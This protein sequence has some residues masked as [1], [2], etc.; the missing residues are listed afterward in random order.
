M[1]LFDP[2]LPAAADPQPELRP[3]RRRRKRRVVPAVISIIL[4]AA[5]AGAGAWAALNPQRIADQLTVWDFEPSA[6]VQA[7]VERL[8]LT[9]HGEFLYYASRPIVSATEEFATECPISPDEADYGILGC[10]YPST[11]L[12]YLFDVTDDRLDGT[13]EVTAA[14]ELLHAAWDRLD[15]D[16][17]ATLEA[18]LEA[19]FERLG[20]DAE[21]VKRM[22]FYARTEPGQRANELHSIIGTEYTGL[23]AELE[24]HYALYFT[25]RTI[26]TSLYERANAA[27]VELKER[28]EALVAALDELRTALETDYASYTAGYATLNADV[29]SFNRMIENTTFTSPEEVDRANARGAAL[30]ERKDTLD[31][32]YASVTERQGEYES[33]L[34][35]L[36]TV[37]ATAAELQR[38]LNIGQAAES[39][40]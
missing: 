35:E 7:H 6:A 27:F 25:D 13:E 19:E 8:G 30:R 36:E 9:E 21:L 2:A 10:Y 34:A 1:T 40:L 4:V 15:A 14:H 22:G 28:G 39:E 26:V 24:A 5:L 32:L 3:R 29:A 23:S 20:D 31:A 37:N 38:S 33:L 12:I 18:L 11:K 17:R 16:E